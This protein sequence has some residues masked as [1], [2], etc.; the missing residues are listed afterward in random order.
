[1]GK[2]KIL[3]QD[4]IKNVGGKDNINSVTHCMTR[5]RFELKDINLVNEEKLKENQSVISTARA[6]GQFQVIVG[7]FVGDV[8]KDIML[9]LD[10]D[11][12]PTERI[13]EKKENEDIITK[14]TDTITKII[15]PTLGVLISA[16]L[17]KGLI[18]ILIALQVLS[19]DSGT[20][21]I[22]NSLGDTL[23]Y[24]FPIILGYT[25]AE[26][27]GLNKFIGM[28]L[29]ASLIYPGI[30]ESMSS[31]NVIFEF[32]SNTPFASKAY[33]TFMGI[34]IIFPEAGY[35]STVI[36]IILITYVGAKLESIL[37]Q[38]IPDIVGF[39]FVPFLTLLICSPLSF[40]IIGPIADVIQSLISWV[41]ISLYEFSPIV[42]AI[43]VALIYQPLVI[44]GLHWPLITLA[45]TNYTSL[46]YDYLWPMMFTASF[47]QTAVVM[48]VGM[49]SENKK[50]KV[51]SIPAIISGLM[52]IIE[53]AI[54]GFSLP[55]K[56]RFAFSCIGAAIGGVIITTMNAYQFTLGIGLFGFA[57][58]VNPSGDMRNLYIAIIAT[59]ITMVVTFTLTYFTYTED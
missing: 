57:G 2:Y 37:K 4:I 6:R 40:I 39:A 13:S 52:C 42:A 27:F 19:P 8:Y 22:L 28:V 7:N 9:E 56:K 36:P 34:P 16:G 44:F 14:L 31:G 11:L 54:Y 35:G 23:F 45:L 25:S 38:W 55:V 59:L 21:I 26:A 32:L 12:G 30:H 17:L 29:G 3:A 24:F 58:F 33:K 46:G 43:V 53:P 20:Y 47:A 51:M 5:L 1:M 15:T 10:L 50:I 41:T 49:R 48:A 18:A